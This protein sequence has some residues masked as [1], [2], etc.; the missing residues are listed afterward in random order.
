MFIQ[1]KCLVKFVLNDDPKYVCPYFMHM[2]VELWKS[3]LIWK[4][5]RVPSHRQMLKTHQASRNDAHRIWKCLRMETTA[6]V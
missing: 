3:S 1:T 6:Y 2:Y 5:E 4:S